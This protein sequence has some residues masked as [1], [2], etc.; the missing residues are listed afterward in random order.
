MNEE[1][2]LKSMQNHEDLMKPGISRHWESDNARLGYHWNLW[3]NA[4]VNENH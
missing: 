3:S 2:F 1:H 4:S